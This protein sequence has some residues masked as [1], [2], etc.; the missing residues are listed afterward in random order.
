V[1]YLRDQRE[2]SLEERRMPMKKHK[3]EEM[4]ALLRQIEAEIAN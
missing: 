1:L 3:P 2:F 4:V